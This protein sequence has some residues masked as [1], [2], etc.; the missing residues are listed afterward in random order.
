[1]P[2]LLWGAGL[3]VSVLWNRSLEWALGVYRCF[4]LWILHGFCREFARVM[5]CLEKFFVGGAVRP[6]DFVLTSDWGV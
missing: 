3:R 4:F 6:N 2:P 5:V 1:M